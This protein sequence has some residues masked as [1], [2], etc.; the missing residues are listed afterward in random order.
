M[1]EIKSLL[2][3]KSIVTLLSFGVFSYLS[4]VGKIDAKDF[5]LILAMVSTYYF[6]K[7]ANKS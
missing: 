5:M 4:I 1:K 3:I 7:D 6:N 2:K